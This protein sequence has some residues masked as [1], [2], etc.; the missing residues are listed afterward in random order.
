MK[1]ERI[2]ELDALRWIAVLLVLIGHSANYQVVSTYEGVNYDILMFEQGIADTLFHRGLLIVVQMIYLFHMPLF[3]SLSGALFRMAIKRGRYPSFFVLAKEKSKQLLLPYIIVTLFYSSPLKYFAGFYEQ[4]ES[5]REVLSK[6]IRGQLLYYG[7][8]YLWFLVVLFLI[9]LIV[10]VIE[11][12]L[13]GWGVCLSVKISFFA[14]ARMFRFAIS[15]PF[16][17]CTLDNIL[18]FYLGYS[19]LDYREDWNQWLYEHPRARIISMLLLIISFY[20][21]K[22]GE[23]LQ[24]PF[25]Y[26]GIISGSI[27]TY[28][29]ALSVSQNTAITS[30]RIVR[31]IRDF[32][33]GL[34]LYAE[35][36]NYSFLRIIINIFSITILGSDI[37]SITLFFVRTIGVGFAAGVVTCLIRKLKL[38]YLY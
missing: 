35:P 31:K 11:K 8:N 10:Y 38:K 3:F 32:S 6:V 25:R 9:F 28:C 33:M 1:K 22:N 2:A 23:N 15:N 37:G 20:F 34:Y 12:Y 17:F 13:C 16:L 24:E 7:N 14:L 29:I 5:F 18:W 26:I 30:N 4:T 21:S 36:L 19:W 27:V